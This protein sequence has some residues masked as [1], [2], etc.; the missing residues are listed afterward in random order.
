MLFRDVITDVSLGRQKRSVLAFYSK[1]QKREIRQRNWML[2]L[3]TGVCIIQA[4][5]AWLVR[6]TLPVLDNSS[7]S[8][9][10]QLTHIQTVENL[11]ILD[12]QG[13][14]SNAAGQT[15]RAGQRLRYTLATRNP[16]TQVYPEYAF[17]D[18]VTDVLQYATIADAG[19]AHLEIIGDS[20]QLVW[21]NITLAPSET[22]VRSFMIEVI[23]PVTS[24][25]IGQTN[26]SSYDLSLSNHFYG[27]QSTISVE[28]PLMKRFEIFSQTLPRWSAAATFLA[29]FLILVGAFW[30][31]LRSQLIA[32]E[33]QIFDQNGGHPR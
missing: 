21:P 22:A 14:P 11:S 4:L 8:P 13:H 16:S 3:A 29:G 28:P 1:R 6:P 20:S 27:S 18:D 33:L 26:Q 24:L 30:L 19:G 12:A 7:K 31:W 23:S 25:A 15:I 2:G 17:Q 10:R 32:R 5:G 9:I